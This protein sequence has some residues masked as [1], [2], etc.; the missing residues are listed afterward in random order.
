MKSLGVLLLM[1]LSFSAVRPPAVAGAFYPG[2]KK[3]LDDEV[4][5]L[6]SSVA[7][8]AL[9]GEVVAVVAPHAGYVYSGPVAAHSYKIL[10]GK[11]FDTVVLLGGSHRA[12]YFGASVA[13]Y[14]AYRTPLGEVPVYREAVSA[15]I[16]AS[17]RLSF[18]PEAHEAEHS[19]EVQLPFLQKVLGEFKIVTI[20]FGDRDFETCEAVSEAIQSILPGD[21]TLYLISTDLSHYYPYGEAVELDQRTIRGILSM[22]ERALHAGIHEGSYF[23]CGGSAVVTGVMLARAGGANHSELLK[24]ANSG[25]TSGDR[26]RVVG[27]SAIAFV[28]ADS[29]SKSLSSEARSELFQIAREAIRG[30]LETGKIPDVHS[31]LPELG[32]N[33]GAFVTLYKNGQ[34]RGCI[35]RH[36]ATTPLYRTVADMAVAAAFQDHRFPPLSLDELD[37]VEIKISVYTMPVTKV[38]SPFDIELGVHGIIFRKGRFQSTYLPEVPVEQGWSLEETLSHLCRKAGLGPDDWK[39]GAEFLVYETEVFGE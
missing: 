3:T 34:L 24:Y 39:E 8:E 11:S 22:D 18:I 31:D 9:D 1:G 7:P 30:Y 28:R 23:C 38:D 19:L 4:T 16:A 20:L 13:D 14:D 25:D 29:E 6:L 2:L 10:E 37:H 35:G 36:A 5:R 17:D 33:T 32:A 27:Y 15:L 26:S 21:R 12:R